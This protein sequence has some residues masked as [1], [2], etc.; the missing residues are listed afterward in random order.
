MGLTMKTLRRRTAA[1]LV[2]KV[3]HDLLLLDT[4]SNRIH[5]LNDTARFIWQKCD[6]EQSAESIAEML[7]DAY[8]V[9]TSTA[10]QDVVETLNNLQALNLVVEDPAAASDREQTERQLLSG[11]VRRSM[12]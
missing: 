11:S 2:R 12:A 3:E 9:E 10:L 8:S 6:G 5:Q 1:V 7:T 4:E